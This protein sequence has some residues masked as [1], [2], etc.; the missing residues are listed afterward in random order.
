MTASE[1][2]EKL[3]ELMELHGDCPVAYMGDEGDYWMADDIIY[4]YSHAVGYDY[5]KGQRLDYD[6]RLFLFT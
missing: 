3:R 5:E 2:I 1:I 6:G 4:E